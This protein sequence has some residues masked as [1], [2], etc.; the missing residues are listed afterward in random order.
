MERK[1]WL[2]PELQGQVLN[3]SQWDRFAIA[4]MFAASCNN[5]SIPNHGFYS[6]RRTFETIATTAD[7]SQAV[8]DHVM[9]HGIQSMAAVYRQKIFDQQ[10]RHLGQHVRGWYLGTVS[11]E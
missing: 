4:R 5:A 6:L 2:W 3:F 1:S 10:L 8:I 11:L 7:V 9:G